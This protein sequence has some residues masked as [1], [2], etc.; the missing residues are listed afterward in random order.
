IPLTRDQQTLL[1]Y[2]LVAARGAALQYPTV[3]DATKAG[4]IIAGGFA[5]GS[6]AHYINYRYALSDVNA[7]G[8]VNAAHPGTLIYDGTSPT[9]RV[10]GVMYTALG[11]PTPPQGFAGLN[12]HWHRHANVCT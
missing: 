7:D 4:M 3:A 9:S 8:T 6:G 11:T 12:D 10:I 2:Q 1:A 5:P